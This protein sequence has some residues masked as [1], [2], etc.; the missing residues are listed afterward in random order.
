MGDPILPLPEVTSS[1]FSKV[2][3]AAPHHPLR[4][5]LVRLLV[6]SFVCWLRWDWRQLCVCIARTN[7]RWLPVVQNRSSTHTIRS[8]NYRLCTLLHLLTT[9][10]LAFLLRWLSD[11]PSSVFHFVCLCVCV[12][13]SVSVLS[14][15]LSLLFFFIFTYPHPPLT[16]QK[17]RKKKRN[18]K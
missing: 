6:S 12:S 5:A 16:R 3:A 2:R 4:S 10:N 7:P 8:N 13:V 18:K 1:P 11:N 17:I 15:L 14:S 9:R